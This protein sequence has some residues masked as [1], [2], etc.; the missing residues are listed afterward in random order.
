MI[1]LDTISIHEVEW[2]VYSFIPSGKI[3]IIQGDPGEG[4]RLLFCSCSRA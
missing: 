1:S 2:L 4:K 3:T